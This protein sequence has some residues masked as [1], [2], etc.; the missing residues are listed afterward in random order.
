MGARD[1]D[2]DAQFRK[3]FALLDRL[4]NP[5]SPPR[6]A[7]RQKYEQDHSGK[8]LEYEH[9]FERELR[10]KARENLELRRNLFLEVM[11]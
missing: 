7:G 6:T 4:F 2:V 1:Q 11:V 10:K 5:P 8:H 9:A 3:I